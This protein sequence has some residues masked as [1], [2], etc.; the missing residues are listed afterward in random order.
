MTV[1]ASHFINLI[2][3]KKFPALIRDI[4]AHILEHPNN[5][6]DNSV[7]VVYNLPL[8]FTNLHFIEAIVRLYEGAGWNVAHY[9]YLV[10][11]D[12]TRNRNT[13][14]FTPA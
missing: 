1:L 5:R 11:L 4:D 6:E 2:C 9:M 7:K 12:K 3:S 8:D 10:D 14:T 13:L